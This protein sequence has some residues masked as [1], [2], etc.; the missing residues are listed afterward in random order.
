MVG[1]QLLF[2]NNAQSVAH[3][4]KY[5]LYICMCVCGV[6]VC[7]SVWCVCVCMFVCACVYSV[8]VC[9]CVY[10]C[11]CVVYIQCLLYLSGVLYHRWGK[12][13]KAEKAYSQAL[14]LD[15][16]NPSTLENLGMLQKKRGTS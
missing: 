2:E 1:V 3:G 13:D 16:N 15:P 6:C 4:V 5:F 9:V 14:Q 12:L 10:V 11:V 8:C 7:V